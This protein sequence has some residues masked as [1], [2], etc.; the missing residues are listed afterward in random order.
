MYKIK[1][2]PISF[3]FIISAAMVFPMGTATAAEKAEQ[4]DAGLLGTYER[5]E[6]HLDKNS[7]GFPLYLESSDKQGRLHVDVY[8]IFDY[9]FS[10]ILNALSVP[11][12]W[13]DI[14]ALHPNVK[15]CTYRGLPGAWHLTFYAGRKVYQSPEDAYQFRYHYRIVE[16]RQKYLQLVLDADEG[17][18]GTKWHKMKF[19]ALPLDSGRTFVHV[20]YA[21]NSGTA[22]RLAEQVY[23]STLGR[24]KVGFT[25]KGI[26]GRGSPVHIDGPRGVIERNAVRYYFAIHSFMSTLRY[27]AEDRFKMRVSEWYDLTN[28][29]KKQLYELDKEE[30]ITFKTEER[31]NQM[32]LQQRV[33]AGYRH[34]SGY[35]G[36]TD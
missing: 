2:L 23:Y 32:M 9:P 8:G 36:S 25:V 20:S 28:R 14:V 22:L 18:F 6:A 5:I 10:S 17:P 34:L 15:A 30:Y 24:G 12:N 21:Y 7:F 35:V 31:K 29:F 1:N 16:E 33:T 26:D 4:A 11:A 13:C 3:L 27:P 19:E